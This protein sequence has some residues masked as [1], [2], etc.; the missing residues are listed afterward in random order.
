M[1][2]AP[3]AELRRFVAVEAD[4]V[5][6]LRHDP[7]G[8]APGRGAYVCATDECYERAVARRAFGR[9]LRVA[10]GNLQVDRE[11]VAGSAA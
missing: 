2:R 10:G 4:G 1:R 11:A 3:K 6:C 5:R 7:A 9:A 8:R